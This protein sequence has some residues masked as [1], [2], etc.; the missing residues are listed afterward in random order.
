MYRHT[1]ILLI[2]WLGLINNIAAQVIQ[3]PTGLYILND[4]LNGSISSDLLTYEQA[5]GYVCRYK[6]SAL[7]TAPNV[8]NFQALLSNIHTAHQ[9]GKKV[10]IAVTAG[11]GTPAWLFTEGAE[12]LSFKEITYR[13]EGEKLI[14]VVMAPPWDGVFLKYYFQFLEELKSV[15]NAD[16]ATYNTVA[17][18]KVCGINNYTAELA[19]PRLVY[20]T[21]GNDTTTN[22]H[23]IWLAAGYRPSKVMDAYGLILKKY[24]KLFKDKPLDVPMVPDPYS[25]PLISNEGNIIH[26]NNQSIAARLINK[27]VNSG[28]KR[29]MIQWN[30]FSKNFVP[31]LIDTAMFNGAQG[32]LQVSF[33]YFGNPSAA[34]HDSLKFLFEYAYAKNIN[35]MEVHP[36]TLRNLPDACTYGHELLHKR[37]GLQPEIELAAIAQNAPNPFSDFTSITLTADLPRKP[38]LEIYNA[39]GQLINKI[40]PVKRGENTYIYFVDGNYLIPGTYIYTVKLEDK[41][42][43][44]KM[45]K[46]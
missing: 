45:V 46:Q 37:D 33:K 32:G 28:S 21:N 44:G 7:H 11:N 13:G 8:Y 40:K 34:L 5:D 26:K 19:L 38:L 22:A 30:A 15:L 20:E 25:F 1:H 23:D 14:N 39:N 2:L 42:L 6:W 9:H 35:Y 27:A 31:S 18:I 10:C 41:L 16:T 24:I 29:M 4:S 36:N 43:S 12:K 17:Q 3:H